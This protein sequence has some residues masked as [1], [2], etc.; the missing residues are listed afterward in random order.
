MPSRLPLSR[1]SFR[2]QIMLLGIIAVVLLFAVLVA[3]FAALQYTKSA[4]LRNE[5]RHLT[6]TTSALAR[7][8]SNVAEGAQR[9][10]QADLLDTS[11]SSV[12]EEVLDGVSKSVLQNVAGVDGGFY[13]STGDALVGVFPRPRWADPEKT[14]TNRLS[15]AARAAVLQSARDAALSHGPSAQILTEGQ[16]ITLINAL[17]LQNH[18]HYVG[19]AWTVMPLSSL[20]GTN[21]FRTYLIA[22]GLGIAAFACVL[23]TLLVVRGL[24]SGVRKIE[25][26]LRNLE[27]NLG[28]E[29][30]VETDPEEIRQIASAINRLGA[31]LRDKIEGERQI[32]DR[33]RH[34]ERLAALGRLIAGVAHEV[35]NPLATIR[36]RLQMCQQDALSSDVKESC[37]IALQEVERLNGMVNRLLSFSRPVQLQAEPTNLGRLVEQRL[38]NFAEL[39]KERHVK[40]VSKFN[41]DSKPVRVDQ[42]RMAQ[43]FDNI[44]RNA[45][46][47]DGRIRRNALCQCH[48][49]RKDCGVQ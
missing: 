34:A 36:L 12:S 20:P 19:S 26:G 48:H 14:K 8:Y 23:L 43:V 13:S 22:V 4:V 25:D 2:R 40:F 7:E 37:V 31:T 39:A 44:I 47:F 32:E 18:E 1:L 9:N 16:D 45:D 28:S 35:R 10:H 24:Q 17:P 29:I 5:Q 27:H 38:G 6:E 3:V 11:D 49:R 42:S 15:A 41:R 46:R 33:L 30:P 21:R